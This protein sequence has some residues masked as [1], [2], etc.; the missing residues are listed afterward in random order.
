M[1][2]AFVGHSFDPVDKNL[3][4]SVTEF[5]EAFKALN[6]AFNWTHAESARPED[7]VDKV[8]PMLRACDIFVGICSKKEYV[9]APAFFRACIW[10]KSEKVIKESDLQWKTSDWVIQEIAIAREREMPLV[11][12]L[13]EGVR[14]PGGLHGNVEYI[15]FQ[16]EKISDAFVRLTQMLG[17]VLVKNTV[18]KE[19]DFKLAQPEKA[20]TEEKNGQTNDPLRRTPNP[21]W[22][23]DDYYAAI[24]SAIFLDDQDYL[25]TVRA[26]FAKSDFGVQDIGL[27]KWEAKK[28]YS[29]LVLDKGGSVEKL[30]KLVAQHRS[31][32]EI[33]SLLARVLSHFK[34]ERG[35]AKLHEEAAQAAVIKEDFQTASNN[36]LIAVDLACNAKNEKEA[37]RLIEILAAL[38]RAH[39]TANEILLRAIASLAKLKDHQL[40][41][42][43]VLEHQVG[44]DPTN[45]D[46]R[47][48]LAYAYSEVDDGAATLM[49]YLAIPAARRTVN[50]WNNLAVARHALKLPV[51]AIDA[52]RVA[53]KKESS[54]AM[55]N[56]ASSYI[57]AGFYLEAEEMCNKGM[58]SNDPHESLPMTFAHIKSVRL[59][60]KK[61]EDEAIE[62]AELRSRLMQK[63][64]EGALGNITR[65]LPA[66]WKG[67]HGPLTLTHLEDEVVISGQY[68]PQNIG[69]NAL[70]GPLVT[71]DTLELTLKGTLYGRTA[72]GTVERKKQSPPGAAGGLLLNFISPAAAIFL[73]SEDCRTIRVIENPGKTF[74]EFTITAV[75]T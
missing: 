8:L 68:V 10:A 70:R 5:L 16:R 14:P 18:A 75:Q 53:D 52:Y 38:P 29:K 64:G 35:A 61:I 54:L 6:P 17:S 15:P 66:R 20:L 41:E 39:K 9:A 32:P 62:A 27:S 40:I 46:K 59:E 36:L 42:I 12:L 74:S 30:E 31:D 56:L 22:Q 65:P 44:V 7:I 47:F 60:E 48:S 72:V 33:I 45:A 2:L 21:S 57:N 11:L 55:S 51:L 63:F 49:H 71:P 19:T 69:L 25:E 73:F 1:A 50:A 43:A 24:F 3:V 34:D 23:A 13:E 67:P 28:E 58:A 37:R 26:Q 4:S